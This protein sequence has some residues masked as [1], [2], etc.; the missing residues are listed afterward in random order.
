MP[1]PVVSP[2]GKALLTASADGTARL[3]DV[4]TG[5]SLGPPLIHRGPVAAA[6]FSADGRVALTGSYDNTARLWPVP[7]ELPAKFERA[8]LWAQVLTGMELD[9]GGVMQALG[10]D[11]WERR[12]QKLREEG[13][14]PLP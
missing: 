4:A 12:R 9:A 8:R 3:W 14:P 13:G 1:G 2:D 11:A 6:A 7:A 5:K 10:A